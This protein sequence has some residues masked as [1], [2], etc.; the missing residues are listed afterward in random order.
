[1]GA[2]LIPYSEKSLQ[3]GGK[4]QIILPSCWG[5]VNQLSP[6]LIVRA[7]CIG[8]V[9]RSPC[10]WQYAE[11]IVD[12]LYI[13]T[14]ACG[15]SP[16]LQTLHVAAG[17]QSFTLGLSTWSQSV[18]ASQFLTSS[19]IFHGLPYIHETLMKYGRGLY[20]FQVGSLPVMAQYGLEEG[21][22]VWAIDGSRAFSI[23]RRLANGQY[24]IV[25]DCYLLPI[26]G[27]DCWV[28]G[29]AQGESDF[30]P[31][32]MGFETRWIEIY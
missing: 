14:K 22:T 9:D 26:Y 8:V 29:S 6:H 3:T 19:D 12:S 32:R 24:Q 16:K 31:F 11:T 15:R 30:D 4:V 23:L 20:I 21:D 1:M 25:S 10:T 17:L 5:N 7:H 27:L 13:V 2:K 18:M 28:P